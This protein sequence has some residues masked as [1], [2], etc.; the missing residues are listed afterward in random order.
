M[1]VTLTSKELTNVFTQD[2]SADTPEGAIHRVAG[3]HVTNAVVLSANNTTAS[4]NC[5]QVTGG[6]QVLSIHGEVMN[7]DTFTNCT[8]VHFDAND[9]TNTVE[10]TKASPGAT[11]SGF[12]VGAFFIKDADVTSNL[13]VVNNDQVR[14]VEAAA[15]SKAAQPFTI[16]QKA[17]TD[18]FIRLTYTTTDA[19]IDAIFR[20]DAVY[21]IIDGG[22]LT[23]V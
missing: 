11:F 19:P 16:V 10:I 6:V 21:S 14:F 9:G 18:T 23:A 2:G 20:V 3:R 17:G 15:G 1:A 5:F 7:A 22:T 12:N 13:S 4:V 8:A